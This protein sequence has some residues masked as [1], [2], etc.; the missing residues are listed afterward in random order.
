[1]TTSGPLLER[2]RWSL[3]RVEPPRDG[4]ARLVELRER[5]ARR[6]RVV[7]AAVALVIAVGGGLVGFRLLGFPTSRP[8]GE[9]GYGPVDDTGH[10]F[11][12]EVL[13]EDS[14]RGFSLRI[15]RYRD[16]R[17][18]YCEDRDLV[19][20]GGWRGSVGGCDYE[21]MPSPSQPLT[22]LFGVGNRVNRFRYVF[23]EVGPEVA[24][25][26][27]EWSD[28]RVTE[29]PPGR[30]RYLAVRFRV[31]PVE[32][33]AVDGAGSVLAT[34]RVPR[35]AAETWGPREHFCVR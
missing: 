10:R 1:M 18:L 13:A 20:P 9:G 19:G 35:C 32:V 28:G 4:L 16:G 12:T 8:G 30:A 2:A 14:A 21:P 27:V 3:E 31:H 15:V 23:G 26:R 34:A 24:E 7:T 25:V 5:R 11:G 6:R 17:G 22:A 29:A 33:T